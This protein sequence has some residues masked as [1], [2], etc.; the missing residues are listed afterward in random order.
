MVR[1]KCVRMSYMC[2][3]VRACHV[4][5][6]SFVLANMCLD[7]RPCHARATVCVRT[8]HVSIFH[9]AAFAIISNSYKLCTVTFTI[10]CAS[11]LNP[12]YLKL[13]THARKPT[14]LP[15]ESI[16]YLN[17]IICSFCLSP[18]SYR[19]NRLACLTRVLFMWRG[20]TIDISPSQRTILR[21]ILRD[22]RDV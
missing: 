21:E 11:Y 14:P 13:D 10:M 1:F 15:N 8:R 2:H 16:H 6:A 22:H 9:R 17:H 7:V 19:Y 4:R 3:G 12:N 20:F 18:Y 5:V